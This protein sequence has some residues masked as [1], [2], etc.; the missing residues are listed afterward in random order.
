MAGAR[1]RDILGDSR[2]AKCCI[3]QYKMRHEAGTPIST[4]SEAA[5]AR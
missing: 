2:L 1:F 3:F 5:G 4:V